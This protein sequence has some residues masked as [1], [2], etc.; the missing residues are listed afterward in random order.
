MGSTSSHISKTT[1]NTEAA[2]Q[3]QLKYSLQQTNFDQ[4]TWSKLQEL[5]QPEDVPHETVGYYVLRRE[6]KATDKIKERLLSQL[7]RAT[8]AHN[9]FNIARVCRTIFG[10]ALKTLNSEVGMNRKA[11]KLT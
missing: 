2:L 1:R 11:T 6:E 8:C 4:N 9:C 10:T 3:S 7:F 5:E